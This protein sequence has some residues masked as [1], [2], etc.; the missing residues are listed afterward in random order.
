MKKGAPSVN[1]RGR[2]VSKML[3]GNTEPVPGPTQ[4]SGSD[5]VRV[6][7][8]YLFD[9][10]RRRELQRRTKWMTLD[11][12][13]LDVSIVASVVNVWTTLGGSAKWSLAPNPLGG[14]DAERGVE[15]V[16]QGLLDAQMSKPWAAIHRKQLM[17]KWRG[18]ALHERVIRRRADGMIVLADLQDRP[19]WTIDRWDKPDEKSPWVG[20]QQLTALGGRYYIPRQRLF[21][22]VEDTLSPTP[23]GVGVLR[24]VAES[25]R[26]LSLYQEFEGIGMQTDLRGI[27]LLRAPLSELRKDAKT[28][29]CKTEDQ[30]T[31]YVMA[32]V[33]FMQDFLDAHNKAPNQGFM[34]DSS[35]FTTLDEQ[36]TPSSIYKWSAEIVQG[37]SRGLPEAAA[38]IARLTRDIARIV[39]AEWLLLGG[40]DSGG[41]YSM[42]E[43]KTA[44]F[45]LMI[46][47]ANVDIAN[48]ARRDL[49]TSL[50]A[51]NGLDPETCT[52]LMIVEPVAT[53]AV[54]S[55][56]RSLLALSQAGLHP[57]DK[58]INVLRGRMDLPDAP[59]IDETDW[60]LPRGAVVVPDADPT[61]VPPAQAG[62]STKPP[63]AGDGKPGNV[64]AQD[65]KNEPPAKRRKRAA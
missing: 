17:K 64:N 30:I 60:M 31:A 54:E 10:E 49:A 58:A 45:G 36:R 51:L 42:H 46:N 57:R 22:S 32:Q 2:A 18:F 38:G 23:E 20:V 33:K 41:A 6:F 5:G 43:D 59:D 7:S 4:A 14:K 25:A 29:G 34:L 62:G 9:G 56:C 24:L 28:A 8:G 55:A 27:P 48:D 1:P 37:A 21:Y 53:Q 15:I 44:M 13:I 35:T 19:Q 61:S 40:E 12:L 50:V 16:Q 52:P 47:S 3:E 63:K 39:C 26:V 65:G 11:N